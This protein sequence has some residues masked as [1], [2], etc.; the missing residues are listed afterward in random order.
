MRKSIDASP[1]VTMNLLRVSRKP[2]PNGEHNGSCRNSPNQDRG[3]RSTDGA[4]LEANDVLAGE[5]GA[6][7]YDDRVAVDPIND[8]Q[9]LLPI[10]GV[11]DDGVAGFQ[12]PEDRLAG[13]RRGLNPRHARAAR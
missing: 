4:T 1:P 5:S 12:W 3:F 7:A 8:E 6:A 13:S 9:S 10:C 2:G 11:H